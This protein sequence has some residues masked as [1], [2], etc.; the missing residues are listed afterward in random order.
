LRFSEKKLCKSFALR[1]SP[2]AMHAWWRL[3]ANILPMFFRSALL[4]LKKINLYNNI[5]GNSYGVF[6]WLPSSQVPSISTWA[7]LKFY[8]S[9]APQWWDIIWWCVGLWYWILPTCGI[10][11]SFELKTLFFK[12]NGQFVP[13]N[14]KCGI[15]IVV[16]P[17]FAYVI[18]IIMCL[19]SYVNI[20]TWWV[21]ASLFSHLNS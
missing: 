7:F 13:K 17:K 9:L 10:W 12:L 18:L 21:R 6:K 1:A 19:L 8:K 4:L 14:I 2:I 5:W 11:P 16:V 20:N 3:S 15:C